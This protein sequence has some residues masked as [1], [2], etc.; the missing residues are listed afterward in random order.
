MY[1]ERKF[2]IQIY[3]FYAVCNDIFNARADFERELFNVLLESKQ[4]RR[5][6]L[7]RVIDYGLQTLR[8]Q[9]GSVPI[10]GALIM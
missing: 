7:E 3:H 1:S 6:A 5:L 2:E 8:K 9:L 10:L 4:L